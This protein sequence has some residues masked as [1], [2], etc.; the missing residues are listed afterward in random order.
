MYKEYLLTYEKEDGTGGFEWFYTEED[1]TER[2]EE[3]EGTVKA[4]DGIHV[5]VLETIIEIANEN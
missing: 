4:L 3:L 5:H 1:L 2:A